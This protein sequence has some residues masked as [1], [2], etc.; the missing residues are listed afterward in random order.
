MSRRLEPLSFH[1]LPPPP[2]PP[3]PP[4]DPPP[5]A[6]LPLG[7]EKVADARLEVKELIELEKLC[8]LKVL[9]PPG[10]TYQLG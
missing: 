9:N 8:G 3:P 2:P 6:P 5:L 7:D 4:E 10:E 1:Q